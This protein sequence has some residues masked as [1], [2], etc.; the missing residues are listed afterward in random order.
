MALILNFEERF[1]LGVPAM[2]RNH[3]EF[4][5]LLERMAVA[6]DAAFAYLYP[7][8]VQHTHAHFA[9]EEVTMRETRFGLTTEHRQEHQRVLG[10]MDWFGRHLSQGRMNLVRIYVSEQLPEWFAQHAVGLD[11][12]LAA[13]IKQTTHPKDQRQE[14][15]PS[16]HGN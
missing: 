14:R 5:D 6:S 11:S 9:A 10:E 4:V 15:L 7:E 12:A 3:R 13:H 2:D 16:A 1:L 8:L